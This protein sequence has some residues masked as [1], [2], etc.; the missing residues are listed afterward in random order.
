MRLRCVGGYEGGFS[1]RRTVLLASS[2][3]RPRRYP[4]VRPDPTRPW[5]VRVRDS[6]D[7]YR[8]RYGGSVQYRPLLV[9]SDAHASSSDRGTLN[10][11]TLN[12]GPT[13]YDHIFVLNSNLPSLKPGHTVAGNLEREPCHCLSPPTPSVIPYCTLP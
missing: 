12:P 11:K 7:L 3:A 2:S 4:A 13:K 9:G 8:D 6:T 5:Y 10:L 1:S